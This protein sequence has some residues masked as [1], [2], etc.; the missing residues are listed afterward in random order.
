MR[1]EG[2]RNPARRRLLAG[3][4]GSLVA[5]ATTRT[6]ARAIAAASGFAAQKDVLV[7]SLGRIGPR[8]IAAGVIDP[9]KFG[10]LQEREGAPLTAVEKEVLRGGARRKIAFDSAS[11]LFLLN[12]FWAVG[13]ANSN[14]L[15]TRGPM[16][17]G[18]LS[19][20]GG[21]A[22]TGGWTLATRRVVDLY[23]SVP[24]V[25]VTD[26][27]QER[28]AEVASQVYRPC[29]DNPTSFPDCN[30]GMAM[31]GLLTLLAADGRDAT[32]LFSAAKTANRFWFPDQTGQVAAYVKTTR[33]LDYADLD[34]REASGRELFSAS[35]YR[36]VSAW[37]M[38]QR[39]TPSSGGTS[40]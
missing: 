14:R 17:R 24:L 6:P 8:L 22:S 10:A 21:Y 11:N 35:G 12:F 15:L 32:A 29:C 38:P 20:I 34:G 23:A 9:V 25:P 31:F 4:G 33:E 40:C 1:A 26:A 2:S 16:A 36:R 30:H 5:A 18:G 3:I 27:Q 39:I 7:L 13:L 37:A 28:L 19:R